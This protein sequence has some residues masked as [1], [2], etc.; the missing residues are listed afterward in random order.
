VDLELDDEQQTLAATARRCFAEQAPINPYVR[1]HVA[2]RPWTRDAAWAAL[3]DVGATG[4]VAP[5]AAGGLD[6]GMVEAAVVA[7][8]AGRALYPG[9]WASSA[10]GAVRAVRAAGGGDDAAGVVRALVA[11]TSIG[12]AVLPASIDPR[13]PSVDITDGRLSGQVEGVLGATVA[14]TLV[15]AARD[16]DTLCIVVVDAASDGVTVTRDASVDGTR[17]LGTV[18]FDAAEGTRLGPVTADDLDAAADA[19]VVTMAADAL[20]AATA[21][22]E[23]AVAYAK[24][25]HQFGQPIGAFQAV[26]HL[27]VDML[28]TVELARGGVLHAAWALDADA[29]DAHRAALRVK[30]FADRLAT[31][32]DTAIQVFG[33]IGYTWEHDSHLFLKR[34]LTWSAYQGPPSRYRRELGRI[35]ARP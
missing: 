16:A 5:A 15:V 35:L 25:R 12:A 24:E 29:P 8:E 9:P 13:G 21:V 31:V 2:G 11:G 10:V 17:D 4:V 20:G 34:L 27:C 6:L 7:E 23:L 32:G 1:E 28:E 30:G 33:G 3:V 19:L 18:T 14:D 26:Q 22:F